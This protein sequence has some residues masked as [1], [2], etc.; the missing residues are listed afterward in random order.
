[1]YSASKGAITAQ[2]RAAITY[3]GNLNPSLHYS[4]GV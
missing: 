4:I 3:Q 1:M 2:T